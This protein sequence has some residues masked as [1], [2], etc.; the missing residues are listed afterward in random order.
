LQCERKQ[1]AAGSWSCSP[2]DRQIEDVL[3]VALVVAF[4]RECY[5]VVIMVTMICFWLFKR[6]HTNTIPNKMLYLK[7]HFNCN[8]YFNL[9]NFTVICSQKWV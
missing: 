5:S 7:G 6:E 8:V 4:L 3:S 1:S 9:T 2:G